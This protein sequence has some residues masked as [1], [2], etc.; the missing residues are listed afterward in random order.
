MGQRVTNCEKDT[1]SVYSVTTANGSFLMK[2][3]QFTLGLVASLSVLED[4]DAIPFP[5]K[6]HLLLRNNA[7]VRAVPSHLLFLNT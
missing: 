2:N 4:K 6:L 1:D 5:G 3:V 7:K